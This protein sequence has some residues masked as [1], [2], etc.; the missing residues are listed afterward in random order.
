MINRCLRVGTYN[1]YNTT[2]RYE[3]GRKEL[4]LHTIND[5]PVDVLGLQE[6]AKEQLSLFHQTGWSEVLFA[7][8]EQPILAEEDP[9]F[10]ID[11]NAI[12]LRGQWKVLPGSHETLKLATNRTAQRVRISHGGLEVVV[13]N[14]HL[15]WSVDPLGMSKRSDAKI[16]QTQ[17]ELLLEW[18][19]DNRSVPTVLV[20]DLN[21]YFS[22]EA[23]FSVLEAAGFK[24]AY[25]NVHGSLDPITVP[26]PLE[27]PTIV[28]ES[29]VECSADYVLVRQGS[30]AP[31]RLKAI[32]AELGGHRHKEG[33]STLYPS[34]H[35]AVCAR[36]RFTTVNKV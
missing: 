14:T 28:L 35:Y 34:D 17:L 25:R 32:E 20:G 36:L 5:L 6:V 18:L 12:L 15:H 9:T 7:P 3:E 13:A 22:D 10:K 19:D 24:S 21:V 23:I 26:T 29:S 4:L 33:D 30:G 27:A 16:R 2:A 8:L 31:V 11:G 1:I